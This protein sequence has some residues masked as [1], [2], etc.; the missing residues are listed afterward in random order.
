M[1]FVEDG[2]AVAE[3]ASAGAFSFIG[4]GARIGAMDGR[5]RARHD[6]TIRAISARTAS[7]IHSPRFGSGCDWETA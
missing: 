6:W 3:D 7:S 5:A 4:E 2:A 1:A